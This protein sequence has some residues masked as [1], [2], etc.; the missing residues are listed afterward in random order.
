MDTA[1]SWIPLGGVFVI[2]LAPESGTDYQF[3]I[4]DWDGSGYHYSTMAAPANV[5][6]VP[7]RLVKDAE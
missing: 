3:G 2:W 6:K 5:Y 1:W 4:F 7:V